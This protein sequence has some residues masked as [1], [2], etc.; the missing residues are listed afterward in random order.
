MARVATGLLLE[1]AEAPAAD[2][3]GRVLLPAQGCRRWFLLQA[4]DTIT[5]IVAGSVFSCAILHM[6]LIWPCDKLLRLW[7]QV[8][9]AKFV[10]DVSVRGTGP[11]KDVEK[12]L[13]EVVDAFI[14]SMDQLDLEVS[15]GAPGEVGG[16]TVALVSHPG[17]KDRVKPPL[18]RRGIDVPSCARNLGVDFQGAGRRARPVRAKRMRA[19]GWRARKLLGLK[20][21]GARVLQVAKVGLKPMVTYGMRCLGLPPSIVHKLRRVISASLPGQHIGRST[22]LRLAMY[23]CDPQHEIAAAPLAAWASAV[24][25]SSSEP[26]VLRLAWRRQQLAVGLAP[27]WSKVRGPAGACIMSARAIGW[28]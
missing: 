19:L 17:L 3:P 16:K 18:R 27:S 14:E 6:V 15:R 12:S 24:W 7:P 2:H 23:G 26:E 4:T 5:A 21:S 22:T 9:L 20:R 28:K 25:D 1:R 11:R 13:P 8:S 10:D